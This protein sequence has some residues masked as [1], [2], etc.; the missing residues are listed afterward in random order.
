LYIGATERKFG[1]LPFNAVNNNALLQPDYQLD[2]FNSIYHGLQTKFTHRMSHGLQ[3][4]GAYTWSHAMD[5]S[6]DP[7]GEA[8]GAHSFPRNS[9]DLQEGWGN[10]DND[11]RHV[12]V[13]NYIWE[14]PFGRGKGYLNGGVVGKILEG[15]QLSGITTIQS[16]HPFQVRGTE[17]TAENRDQ[18]MGFDQRRRSLRSGHQSRNRSGEGLHHQPGR[19]FEPAFWFCRE[20][21]TESVL[22]A[23]ILGQRLVV[24]QKNET[25]GTRAARTAVRGL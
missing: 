23:G 24:R 11:T 12:A 16:G 21:G 5:D 2:E 14:L 3:V 19:V 10:S 8:I 4:Q 25:D 22:W 6:V 13:F 9:R 17:D 7:L 20:Y 18:R 15:M 1:D